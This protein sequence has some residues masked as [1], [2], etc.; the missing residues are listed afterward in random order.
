MS[1]EAVDGVGDCRRVV[2]DAIDGIADLGVVEG[3][4]GQRLDAAVEPRAIV[5]VQVLRQA[6]GD[7]VVEQPEQP[8]D[9]R[10]AGVGLVLGLRGGVLTSA[11][12][13][14]GRLGLRAARSPPRQRG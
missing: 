4:V 2:E 1:S 10:E 13:G 6:D 8:A 5:M 11:E 9:Q 14:F 12:P 3:R 7:E